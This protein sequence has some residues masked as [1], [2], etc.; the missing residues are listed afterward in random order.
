MEERR[1]LTDE[2]LEAEGGEELP[3]REAMSSIS[4]DLGGGIDN[5]AMPINQAIAINN[6]SVQSFAIADAD[7]IVDL[8]MVADDTED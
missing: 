8:N 1:Q 3:D 7:Q 5:F 2:E 4:L 6:Q